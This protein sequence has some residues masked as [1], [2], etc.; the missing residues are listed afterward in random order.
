[1]K[2]LVYRIEG[3]YSVKILSLLTYKYDR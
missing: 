3:F 2:K 1:M